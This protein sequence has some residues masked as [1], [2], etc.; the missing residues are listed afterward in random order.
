ME[1]MNQRLLLT[2]LA[3]LLPL[4]AAADAFGDDGSRKRSQSH[5]QIP[6]SVGDPDQ[7]QQFFSQRLREAQQFGGLQKMLEDRDLRRL[8]GDIQR[9]PENFNNS[10]AM[11]MFPVRRSRTPN[12]KSGKTGSTASAAMP[13]LRPTPGKTPILPTKARQANRGPILRTHP[14]N[15]ILRRRRP[16]SQRRALRRRSP[17][18][19]QRILPVRKP[20]SG[21]TKA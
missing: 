18:H 12:W 6:S 1:P 11:S 5:V 19:L 15:A 2:F 16:W 3:G 10:A 14:P 7:A 20:S 17:I 21:S 8:V 9:N 4:L 13:S